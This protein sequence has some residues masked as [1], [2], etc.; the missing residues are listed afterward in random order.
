[1]AVL[2][3]SIAT[4]KPQLMGGGSIMPTVSAQVIV[5][6]ITPEIKDRIEAVAPY[7]DTVYVQVNGATKAPRMVGNVKVSYFKWCDD[8]SAARNALWKEVETDYT[9]WFDADDEIKGLENLPDI[10]NH[11]VVTGV[12]ILFTPYHYLVNEQG[13][14]ELQNRERII[15]TSLPGA[16]H[17]AVHESWIPEVAATRETAHDIQWV[18][19]KDKDGHNDSMLRNR[20]ILES[21]YAKEPRDPRIAY[22]L[23]LNYG[24]DGKYEQAIKC[25]QELIDTGGWDEERYRAYLQIFS[26]HFELKNYDEAA[27]AA[28]EATK[29]LP[30]WPDAYC[31]LQ[32][33]YYQVDDHT[34]SLEWYK[35]G[36]TKPNP[37]SDSAFNPVVRMWQP[38]KLAAFSYL[39]TG[40]PKEAMATLVQ[41]QKANPHFEI[42]PELKQETLRAVNEETAIRNAKDLIEFNRMY[43]GD[44]KA[45]LDS[46]PPYLRADVRL[47]Q[48]RRELIPGKVWPKG[49]IAIYCGPSYE[50]WGP[51]TLDKGMGGSEEAIVYLARAL[52]KNVPDD[53][54]ITVYNERASAYFTNYEVD[55]LPWTE[56]NP[57][58]EFDTYIQWRSPAGI[59][60]IKARK[61]LLDLHDI[62]PTEDVYAAIPYVDMFMFKSKFHRDLYPEVPEE[63]VAIV[64]NG[65]NKGDFK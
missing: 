44:P 16:W 38:M 30:E 20:R 27:S 47:T 14:Q 56:I 9:L 64:G 21:E 7:V 10:I 35:V 15:R 22:Y 8:F 1:M 3:V 6:E 61:K 13:T 42:E 52:S 33:L 41:L 49:S 45:V 63:K 37:E 50:T 51:D 25:F 58:D 65:I 4:R 28:L 60:N 46:L 43:E 23:G 31:L 32:Q 26:C 39:F 34:K 36:R 59:E 19:L 17:G 54:G 53:V 12:D 18:H 55:Y 40:Q 24:M 62:I 5:K 2:Y 48:Q 57:N 29:E 11:M